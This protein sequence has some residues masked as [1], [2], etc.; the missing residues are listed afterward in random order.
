M[1]VH[2]G[3]RNHLIAVQPLQVLGDIADK[4]TIVVLS[5][6]VRVGPANFCLL[7]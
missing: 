6:R 4:G 1:R 2:V 7:L 3:A 5:D